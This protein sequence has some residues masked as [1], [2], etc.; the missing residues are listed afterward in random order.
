MPGRSLRQNAVAEVEN[1]RMAAKRHGNGACFLG[2]SRS[3]GQQCKWIKIALE[4][5]LARNERTGKRRIRCGVKADRVEAGQGGV[6]GQHE[7]GETRKTHQGDAR[8]TLLQGR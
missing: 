4:G 8:K 2:Q 7:P 5:K 6:G 3:A 1:M